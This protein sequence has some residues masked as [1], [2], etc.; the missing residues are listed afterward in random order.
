MY[1]VRLA[2]EGDTSTLL[3]GNWRRLSLPNSCFVVP[4]LPPSA[5]THV[6]MCVCICVCLSVCLCV[7]MCVWM[8]VCVYVCV[9]VMHACVCVM[10]ACVCVMHACVYSPEFVLDTNYTYVGH[11]LSNWFSFRLPSSLAIPRSSCMY[12]P[13]E[14]SFLPSH[15]PDASI[16]HPASSG[17]RAEAGGQGLWL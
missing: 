17:A 9:C 3:M 14:D 10:H 1:P 7:C 15:R 11:R 8:C 12:I 2:L 13:S 4:R 16:S 5:Y 6:C